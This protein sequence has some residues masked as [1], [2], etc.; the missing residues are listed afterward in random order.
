MTTMG[1]FSFQAVLSMLSLYLLRSSSGAVLCKDGEREALLKFKENLYD[2]YGLLSTW[3]T[4]EEKQE[5]CHWVGIRCDN[6]SGHVISLDVH[7]LANASMGSLSLRGKIFSSSLVALH[8]LSYLDLSWIDFSGNQIP[9]FFGE[10]TSLEYL[11]LAHDN[12]EGSIPEAFGNMTALVQLD[13][14]Y[15]MLEGEIWKS[16]IWNVCTLRILSL[17]TN[18]FR[19]LAH[20]SEISDPKSLFKC[21]NYF[22]EVLDLSWNPIMGS[23]PNLRPFSSLKELRLHSNQING[24]VPDSVGQLSNLE[25]LDI[26]NNSLEGVVSETHFLKLYTLKHLDLSLNQLVLNISSDWIPPF[27][28][29]D[30]LLSYCKLGPRFPKWLRTQKSYTWLDISNTGISESIPSWFWN[31][32]IGFQ[33]V[34]LSRNLISGT[35]PNSSLQWE[36]YPQIDLSSN[37]LEG[38]IP[39]FLF[40]VSALYLSGNQL[41]GLNGLCDVRNESQLSFLDVSYNQLSGTLP[42]CWSHFR[43]LIVLNLANNELSGNIPTTIGSL[44]QIE[45]LHLGD[46]NFTSELPITLKNCTELVVI[47]VGHNKLFGPIPSWT[48]DSLTKL[49]ILVLRSNKFYGSIPPNI[50]HLQNL[51]LLDMSINH[52]DGSIPECVGNFSEMRKIGAVLPTISYSYTSSIGSTEGSTTVGDDKVDVVWKGTLSQFGSTLGLVKGIDLS[53]NALGG[54]IPREITQLAG[55][56]SLNLSRN[57]MEGQIPPEIGNMRS[58]DALDL[59]DNRLSG[60]IPSS[61]AVID[62]LG[63]LNLSNNDLSGKIPTGTQLQSFSA[64]SYVG[65]PGLCGAP[66]DNKCFLSRPSNKEAGSEENKDEFISQGF[67]ASLGVGFLVGF[68]GV[69]GTL[70]FNRT[71]RS[72]ALK[73]FG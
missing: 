53:C 73:L 37:E 58:L 51:Q 21:T 18:K 72:Q 10:M 5:C 14:S 28:L 33:I 12:L 42:N 15:N 30:I 3:G 46:N 69:C 19:G 6:Q 31:S 1:R 43:N 34:D 7:S 67:Y 20:A 55:L 64:T 35:I 22:L 47:D 65:N 23:F 63:V 25:I 71:W 16:P 26:S 60:H 68:L 61:L 62:R 24:S 11:N 44:T 38:P 41:S 50:C 36:T 56:V 13:L 54:Q 29:D 9:S 48:G 66:L 40:Q 27:Q 59:S 39:L 17:S 32:S 45:V 4:E 2:D 52:I 8:Y 49:A 57:N 70:L